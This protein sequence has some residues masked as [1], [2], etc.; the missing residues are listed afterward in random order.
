MSKTEF[1][2]EWIE[3]YHVD[4]LGLSECIERWD[5]LYQKTEGTDLSVQAMAGDYGVGK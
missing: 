1:Y 2:P 4:T 5:Y 3:K